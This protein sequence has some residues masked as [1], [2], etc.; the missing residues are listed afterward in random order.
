MDRA[1]DKMFCRMHDRR[2]PL[3][4]LPPYAGVSDETFERFAA[5]VREKYPRWVPA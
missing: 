5:L 2:F 3:R 1:F 4:L